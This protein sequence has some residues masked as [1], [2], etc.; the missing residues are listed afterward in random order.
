[1]RKTSSTPLASPQAQAAVTRDLRKTS[2][3]PLASPQAQPAQASQAAGRAR[4]Q[5]L[6]V[7][8]V[9]ASTPQPTVNLPYP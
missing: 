8:L 7:K 3:T 2:S 1:L 5:L 6:H 4:L 9:N